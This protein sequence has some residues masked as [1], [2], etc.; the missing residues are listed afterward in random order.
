M[1]RF[2][3]FF[4]LALPPSVAAAQNIAV[5]SG[6]HG[7]FS[8][9]VFPFPKPV[10]WKMGRVS[11]GYE[12]RLQGNGNNIDI[13][14]VYR[15]I[16]HNRIKGISVSED[17]SRILLSVECDCHADAFEFRPGLLVVDIKDGVPRQNSPFEG[18]FAA[19]ETEAVSAEKHPE[20]SAAATESADK[21]A[22]MLFPSGIT[23]MPPEISKQSERITAM[24]SELLRQIGRA[25]AHG[26]LKANI[27]DPIYIPQQ[28]SSPETQ[29]IVPEEP[30]A[31]THI[32]I[33]IENSIDREAAN[34]IP[35]G[36]NPADGNI[37][38]DSD[39]VNVVE[40]GN[41]DAVWEQISQNRRKLS[42]EFDK[43]NPLAAEALA[44]AYIYAGFGAEALQI[45]DRF[46]VESETALILKDIA[47]IVDDLLPHP[48]GV[49]QGQAGCDTEVALWAVMAMPE[50][51]KGI[52]INRSKVIYT[53][54]E[55]PLHLR[56]HLGPRL[57]GKFL[58][59][60]D[61]ETATA[62]R[63][64]IARAHGDA[65][66]EF[67]LMDAYIKEERGHRE[68]AEQTIEKIATTNN[69]VALKAL[70]KLLETKAEQKLHVKDDLLLT[71]ESY[72]FEQRKTAEGAKL[73]RSLTLINA[74]SGN[75]DIALSYLRTANTNTY[76]TDMGF[77][78]EEVLKTATHAASDEIFLK[79]VFAAQKDI[80]KQ[81]ISPKI[82][83]DVAKR[84]LDL[85]FTTQALEIL[86]ATMPLSDKGRLIMAKAA[87]LDGGA[88]RVESLLETVP[89]DEAVY[90]R[91][92][93]FKKLGYYEKAAAA[94]AEISDFDSQKSA[95]WLAGD[96]QRLQKIGTDSERSFARS[97][98]FDRQT[99]SIDPILSEKL[100]SLGASLIEESV[101][102]R[103]SAEAL[104]KDYPATLS[105]D[106]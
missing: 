22:S 45:I 90:L 101:H 87:L 60:G 37:C 68:A 99:D 89:G 93:A 39:L 30:S 21:P 72:L 59:A 11:D 31:Q 52:K 20:E 8:R 77:L 84:M 44:K 80:S 32:N 18:G 76:I 98:K 12:I 35:K 88:D 24:Q 104:I 40:W 65:G 16:S 53:F 70:I 78:W 15:R 49:F 57:A 51:S 1:I 94:F 105:V 38:F 66:D 64:A 28:N 81:K 14:K 2:I 86:G 85:G 5:R 97:M 47:R 55:L 83:Q 103:Q 102:F 26:L 75:L 71:A 50:L 23:L 91:A 67:R 19:D 61:I 41:K 36:A 4:L 69:A 9:L 96:W 95:I 58:E 6:E 73:L 74:Q 62:I 34:L 46:G 17:F 79:F 54:S 29:E 92:E 106:D 10:E 42:G 56:R 48:S 25:A 33:H 82:R 43:A 27:P 63:N 3:L 7:D 13:S 100:Q